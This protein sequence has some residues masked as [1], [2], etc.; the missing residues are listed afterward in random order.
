MSADV[1]FSNWLTTPPTGCASICPDGGAAFGDV[2]A[3]AVCQPQPTPTATA[4]DP[5]LAC[6]SADITQ[7]EMVLNDFGVTT[8]PIVYPTPT[9]T[10]TPVIGRINWTVDELQ[11]ICLSVTRIGQAFIAQTERNVSPQAIFKE[12]MGVEENGV[13]DQGMIQL[14]RVNNRPNC[15]ADNNIR[16]ITCGNLARL[17]TEYVI[18]HEFGHLFDN[19][20]AR[21]NGRALREYVADTGRDATPTV[22]GVHGP[23]AILDT[24]GDVVMG[25]VV[26]CNNN[27]LRGERGWG[28]GPGSR[29]N[30]L[31][32]FCTPQAPV[33]TDFQ[34]NTPPYDTLPEAYE[35]TAADMFLNWVYRKLDL[36]GFLNRDWRPHVTAT[37]TGPSCNEILEGC[38]NSQA[39]SGDARFNWMQTVMNEIFTARGWN[40]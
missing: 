18:T 29:Y 15:I 8:M 7:L 33:Y 28:S 3:L 36:G 34:Q 4:T 30:P 9:P 1:D 21:Q 32:A 25:A 6:S 40:S 27:W 38:D 20:A 35:E 22:P 5:S 11:Q 39:A 16:T 10:A 24:N 13:T 2:S 23:G 17:I 19:Q 14:I 31:T 26:S 37:P 12:V